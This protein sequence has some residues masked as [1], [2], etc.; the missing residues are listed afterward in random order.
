MYSEVKRGSV[1]N[2]QLLD[3]GYKRIKVK[4]RKG[5]E[6]SILAPIRD[7]FPDIPLSADANSDYTVKDFKTLEKIGKNEDIKQNA[8]YLSISHQS[9]LYGP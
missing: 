4:I 6:V 1:E 7:H 8:K 9:N 2:R 5:E 3:K